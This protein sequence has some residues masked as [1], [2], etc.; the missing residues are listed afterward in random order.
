MDEEIIDLIEGQFTHVI[1]KS[2]SYMVSRF[3]TAEGTITVTGPS[4]EYEKGQKYILTGQYVEHPRYGF[5]FSLLTI[6]KYLPSQKEEIISFLR[7]KTFPGIGK[8][9]AEKIYD[10]FGNETLSVLKE[11]PSKIL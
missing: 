10:H 3:Q 6:E 4:F 7:G 9:A 5:Q 11:D 1:Y 2:E 8:K